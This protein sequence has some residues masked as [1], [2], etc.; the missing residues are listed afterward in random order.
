MSSPPIYQPGTFS[1][2]R[3]ASSASLPAYSPRHSAHNST[4][5]RPS[6]EHIFTL[7]NKKNKIWA[8]LKVFSSA[9]IPANLPTFL[10]GDKIDGTLSVKIPPNEKISEVSILV[11]G[12][13][14]TGSQQQDS[15]CFLNISVP[16]WSK[17]SGAASPPL[18]GDYQWPFSIPIPKEVVLQDPGIPGGVRTYLLP[19]TFLE[20][21]ARSSAHYH[22]SAK[23]TRSALVV[24][25]NDDELKTMFIYVPALRPEPPSLLRQLA[26]TSNTPIP[27]PE[28]DPQGWHTCPAVVVRGSV[29]NNRAIEVQCV[30]SLSKPL[31]YTRGSAIPCSISYFCKD[32]QALNL[33]CTPTSTDV[34][35]CREVKCSTLNPWH[36]RSLFRTGN[37]DVQ[38]SGRA[39]WWPAHSGHRAQDTRTFEGEIYLDKTLKP[40]SSISHFTLMYFVVVMP[41]QVTGFA[42]ANTQPL[43]RQEVQ[44]GTIFAKVVRDLAVTLLTTRKLRGTSCCLVTSIVASI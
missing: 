19:Q 38:E 30:F 43:I 39:V 1:L 28:I 42:A 5:S 2:S 23:I 44:I 41:F 26:Y 13:I 6:T 37:N 40:S 21:N 8:T 11:R 12:E 32:V 15:L 16:L 10:E 3:V 36:D 33:L 17:I 22:I 9:A 31:S 34:R 20:R 7:K 25:Q 24:L 27:G 18:S 14:I 29:F 35:L 4:G